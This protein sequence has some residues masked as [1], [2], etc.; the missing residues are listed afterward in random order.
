MASTLK[1]RVDAA[2]VRRLA[3]AVASADRSFDADA[4]VAD[5]T[6][7]L[8]ELEL[9]ER[10]E[11]IAAALERHLAGPF[12]RAAQVV[13]DAVEGASLDV[14]AAWACATYLERRGLDDPAAALD[15]MARVTRH[16][17]AEFAVRPLIE[18]HPEL[19]FA[20]LA[21]WAGSDDQHLRR[22]VSE[23][24]RPRLP[25]G[26]R[27]LALQRDPSPVLPLLDRLRDDPEEYVR[28][29]VANHLNDIAKDHPALALATARRWLAEGGTHVGRVVSHGLRTLIKAGDPE[30]LALVGAES[31]ADVELTELRLD[32]ARI[33]LGDALRFSFA[34]R[35]RA[36]RPVRVVVDY[37]L[38]FRRANGTLSP[39]VFK[40][41]NPT[42]APGG[43][44]ELRRAFPIRPITTRRYYPGE[45]RLEIQVSGRILAA[46]TFQ[47]VV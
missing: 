18:R 1:E 15:A 39:K 13:G 10:M 25:W 44:L 6:V 8:D 34:L 14:W 9:K 16:A 33:R 47:L 27:L 19:T 11:H 40:L 5:A 24:T 32:E 35:N 28:R 7:G 22:L 21:E 3:D 23:G 45:Q 38:H 46:A 29:S 30:A 42:L 20:R 31:S 36:D 4:F 26:R 2:L 12:D 37:V 17:S 41:A 43:T